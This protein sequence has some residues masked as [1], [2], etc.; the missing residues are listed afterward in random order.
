MPVSVSISAHLRTNDMAKCERQGTAVEPCSLTATQLRAAYQAGSLT[1]VEVIEALFER[2]AAVNSNLNALYESDRA[3]ALDSAREAERRWRCGRPAGL[4]DGVPISVKDHLA[5][6]GFSSPRG[7]IFNSRAPVTEDCAAV[8]RLRDSGAILFGK[9]T[10]PELSIMP[11]TDSLAFGP[12]RHPMAWD[13]SPG[14]SSGG[15]AVAVGSGMGPLALATDGG[16]SIRIPSALVGLVGFKPTHGRVPYYPAPTDRTVAGPIGRTVA[17]VALMM[18][19]IARSDPRD[20]TQ[21]PPDDRDYLAELEEP[22]TRLRIAFSPDFGYQRVEPDVA[23]AVEHAVGTLE[24]LGHSVELLDT[25]CDDVRNIAN[26]Q[27]ALS[28]W[29]LL[30]RLSDEQLAVLPPATRGVLKFVGALDVEA[31]QAMH[32]GRENLA[33]QLHAVFAD[34]DILVSPTTPVSTVEIGAHYPGGDILG[35]ACRSLGGFTRPFNIVHMPAI[36]IPCGVDR[37][38]FPIGVQIAGPK[39]SD[40]LLLRVASQLERALMLQPFQSRV[41]HDHTVN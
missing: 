10:M 27:A 41:T 16:G 20:W 32:A 35:D 28:T 21:L 3:G 33:K 18:N 31:I 15:A 8:A 5:V 40:S 7:L 13:R 17:D 19:V 14:G 30:K 22:P 23:R 38:G 11:I 12:T 36:S 6:R 29:P 34:C 37:D 39:Y 25:V 4:L 26:V 24:S 1:P 9:S 2:I